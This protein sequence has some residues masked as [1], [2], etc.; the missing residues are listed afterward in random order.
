VNVTRPTAVIVTDGRPGSLRVLARL[1]LSF[2]GLPAASVF[3]GAGPLKLRTFDIG[4]WGGH[5]GMH[6]TASRTQQPISPS[7][8]LRAFEGRMD[9][10]AILST[11]LT[12]EEIRQLDENRRITPTR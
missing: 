7:F 10:F 4:N 5:P 3:T 9:E 12:D 2:T 1:L 11:A 6:L 8:Y